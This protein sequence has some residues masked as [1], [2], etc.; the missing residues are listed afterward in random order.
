MKLLHFA[1]CII[2]TG[3]TAPQDWR[4]TQQRRR[5]EH[6]A[7]REQSERHKQ[8]GRSDCGAFD[9][10]PFWTLSTWP[11]LLCNACA[12]QRF[13][14]S[15]LHNSGCRKVA[16]SWTAPTTTL[17]STLSDF[18]CRTSSKGRYRQL[19]DCYE[20]DLSVCERSSC[21]SDLHPIAGLYLF[22]LY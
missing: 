14:S 1:S 8:R 6:A 18:R 12:R 9:R 21:C 7:M 17:Q 4:I 15:Q 11:Q 22:R 3:G 20:A 10:P 19:A 2:K 5:I 16:Q 13:C